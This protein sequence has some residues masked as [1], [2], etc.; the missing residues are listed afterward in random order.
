MSVICLLASD[1]PVPRADRRIL[2]ETMVYKTPIRFGQEFAVEHC[3][4]T[5]DENAEISNAITR[6]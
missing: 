6:K 3:Y 1:Y 5:K 4:Y 2:K